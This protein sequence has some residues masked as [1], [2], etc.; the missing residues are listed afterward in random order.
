MTSGAT[1][2]APAPAPPPVPTGW[3]LWLAGARPRTLGAAVAP[4]VVGTAV[5]VAD[6]DRLIVW[7]AAAALVVA[8]ALQVGVNYA[9]DYSDGVRG[10]D[11]DRV[12]PL[13]LTASGLVPAAAVRRASVLS[14]ALAGI[15]GAL[16]AIFVEPWL[17]AVGA[18]SIAAG[19]LY[20]GGPR[21][22]GYLGL[23][24]IMVLVFF[25][26]VAT[27]GS[28]FVQLERIPAA[29]WWGSLVVGL[30][31]CAILLANN[32]RDVRGDAVAAKRTL[33]VRIG[34][35]AARRCFVGC[36][37]GSFAAVVAIGI[38][39]PWALLALGAI[40]MAVVP[41]RGVLTASTPP[42]LVR[43]LVATAR[44]EVVVA[45]ALGAGLCLS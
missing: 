28:A 2:R 31:A 4:V 42:E 22:Y 41:V 3:R 30:L 36:V 11:A 17:F 27:T 18:A 14:F 23:G 20:T 16:L 33:A 29:A 38:E 34:D 39:R 24:E 8:L 45:L 15:A 7:R 40:P 13:R 12:G 6:A 37:A 19:A 9:N 44:L 32:I 1:R 43:V 5:G 10:T 21:P 26:F 25:G 35:R